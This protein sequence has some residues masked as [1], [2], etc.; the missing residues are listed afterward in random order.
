MLFRSWLART[1][2]LLVP[3]QIALGIICLRLGLSDPWI[4]VSHQLVAAM[5]VALLGACW[6][7]SLTVSSATP[8]RTS[9]TT[10]EMANG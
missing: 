2:A 7:Q 1:A 5:L 8:V 4:T 6:G 9:T 3:V 10:L